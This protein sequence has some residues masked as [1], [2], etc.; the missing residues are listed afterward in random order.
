MPKR[1]VRSSRTTNPWRRKE[2]FA[3]ALLAILLLPATHRNVI[4][5]HNANSASALETA[6]SGGVTRVDLVHFIPNKRRQLG[7]T[8]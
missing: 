6:K 7:L 1:R 4:R 3:T 8:I 2:S 5:P